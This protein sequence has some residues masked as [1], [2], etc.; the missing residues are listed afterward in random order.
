MNFYY[1]LLYQM[2]FI[3]WIWSPTVKYMATFFK[4][5]I[6]I[7]RTRL[8]Q[9]VIK[10][11][12]PEIQDMTMWHNVWQLI[13]CYMAQF[14]RLTWLN[15]F[16]KIYNLYIWEFSIWQINFCIFAEPYGN[17]FKVNHLIDTV[18]RYFCSIREKTD[19][20]G[21]YLWQSIKNITKIG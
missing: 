8:S 5:F 2:Y 4:M 20:L 18:G 9:I 1:F 15:L 17:L 16:M 14:I 6:Y 19:I 21:V 13:F 10:R 11:W 7:Y 3:N 12:V